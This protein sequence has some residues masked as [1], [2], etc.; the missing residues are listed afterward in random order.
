MAWSQDR[1]VIMNPARNVLFLLLVIAAGA[2][3]QVVPTATPTVEPTVTLTASAT[4]RPTSTPLPLPVAQEP[5]EQ[6]FVRIVHAVAELQQIDVY[7]EGLAVAPYLS[8]RQL[9]GLTPIAAGLHRVIVY[10]AGS[11]LGDVEPIASSA[12]LEFKSG[13]S[14]T[15]VLSGKPDELAF[16]VHDESVALLERDQS[17]LTFINALH[18]AG[19]IA[20]Q[21]NRVNLTPSLAFGASSTIPSTPAV[22]VAL[23][24]TSASGSILSYA[25][26]LRPRT[27]HTLI[28]TGTIVAP[29]V[30]R[31][32]DRV[33]GA[34][35]VRVVNGSPALS[36]VDVYLN[37]T[38]LAAALDYT[39]AGPRQTLPAGV[40]LV[41]VYSAGA[42]RSL[43]EPLVSA[44]VT[45]AEDEGTTIVLLGSPGAACLVAARDSL[46]QTT[47]N[48]A[49]VTFV[50]TLDGAPRLRLSVSG[51]P[52]P[53]AFLGYGDLPQTVE[54]RP[55]AEYSFY[56]N[57]AGASETEASLEI[58]QDVV[59]EAGRAYL[60]LITGRLDAPPVILSEYVGVQ[61]ELLG[62]P[63]EVTPSAAPLRPASLAVVN[64]V[65]GSGPLDVFLD[66]ALL[67]ERLDYGDASQPISAR[68]GVFTVTVRSPGTPDPL[69]ED[70]VLFDNGVSYTLVLIG[71]GLERVLVLPVVEPELTA[72]DAP[73]ARLINV[74]AGRPINLGLA[75]AVAVDQ[76]VEASRFSSPP[77]MGALAGTS[78]TPTYRQSIGF[79][80][81]N[82]PNASSVPPGSYSAPGLLSEGVFD[83]LIL[84]TDAAAIAAKIANV[85]FQRGV[86]YDVY[87]LRQPDSPIVQGFVVPVTVTLD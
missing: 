72:A 55:G 59:F 73:L 16:I 22:E 7:V 30:V 3:A 17:R 37:D 34:A 84:D 61:Q 63:A 5:A 60:Y 29:E 39:R 77:Q 85:R 48:A 67:A 86:R 14:R 18:S 9:T 38:L 44:D 71:Y 65:F 15:V 66:G 49:R 33:P 23:D 56:W 76:S 62:L 81:Q 47:P 69:F 12:A 27:A 68:E 32:D 41:Q 54:V 21:Q 83:L 10:P 6:A 57:A 58:A 45:A 1:E 75:F 78:V 40:Y 13:V 8:F 28:L 24:F 25:L 26:D 50:N 19:E 74:T 46:A 11:R 51:P 31:F 82:V 70:S 20:V 43:A 52:L 79:G 36:P 87:A 2:C 64:A 35:A 4:P 42:D 80:V 53:L